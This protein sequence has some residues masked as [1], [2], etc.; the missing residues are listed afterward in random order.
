MRKRAPAGVLPETRALVELY[1]FMILTLAEPPKSAPAPARR[2]GGN[3]KVDVSTRSAITIAGM[4]S[5]S[6]KKLRHAW[7]SS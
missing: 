2:V 7:L 1:R 5:S 6:L 4:S 3:G